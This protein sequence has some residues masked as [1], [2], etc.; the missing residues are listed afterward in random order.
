MCTAGIATTRAATD[1]RKPNKT[2]VTTK[3]PGFR[4]IFRTPRAIREN[5][6]PTGAW[7]FPLR[8]LPLSMTRVIAAALLFFGW[9]IKPSMTLRLSMAMLG[10]LHLLGVVML[11]FLPRDE[12]KRCRSDTRPAGPAVV[13]RPERGQ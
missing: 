10:G 13:A 11:P 2:V 6:Y 12:A 8:N 7:R 3:R 4:A 5:P 9:S 1:D